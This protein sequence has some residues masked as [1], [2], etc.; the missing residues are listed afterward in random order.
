MIA[1]RLRAPLALARQRLRGLLVPEVVQTSAMDCGPAALKCL[2]E[3][4]GVPVSYGR[5]REACQTSVDG[6]SI[7]A[8]EAVAQQLGL[9]AEQV[10]VP[11][12]FICL[13]DARSFP[14]LVVVRHAEHFTHFVVVWARHGEWL[15]IMDPAV[16][17]RWIARRR[18]EAEI[19]A[20]QQ[21]VDAR[22]WR[23][24]C[25]SEDFRQP[26]LRRMADFGVAAAAAE[27]L[28]ARAAREDGWFGFGALDAAVRLVAALVAARGL[29]RGEEAGRTLAALFVDTVASGGDIF[30]VIPPGYW[31]AIPDIANTDPGREMLRISGGVMLRTQAG[32]A[33]ALPD[34]RTLPVEL[35]A[36][37]AGDSEG[38]LRRCW[39]ILR[40][41]R[42]LRPRLVGG[43]VALQ[44]LALLVQALLM[45]ALIELAQLL[46][47]PC[48]RLA[49]L[50]A[51]VLLVV[52]GGALDLALARHAI[53]LGRRLEVRL[54]QALLAKLPRLDERYFQSR[55]IT[56]MADR[57]HLIH[58]VRALPPLAV[59]AL[60]ALTALA[61]TVLAVIV[62]A[63]DCAVPALLAVA[64]A[65]GLPLLAQPLLAERD[66]RVRNHGGALHGFYL[67][68]LLGLAPIR[69][70]RAQAAI[71]RQH[72]G[73]LVEWA[74][75]A[76][77]FARWALAAQGLQAL[78][79]LGL[80]G[81]MLVRHFGMSGRVTGTDLLLVFWALQLPA[82]ADA[83]SA[84][85]RRYPPIRNALLRQF[86]P[87][88]APE[89]AGGRVAL[90]VRGPVPRRAGPVGIAI[91][92]GDVV[93]GGHTIL[94]EIELSIAPGEHVAIV[95]PSGAGKSSL[96]GLLLGWHR[97]ERGRL[98]IDGAALTPRAL[99]ALRRDVAWVDPQVQL[100]NRS[101][102]DN[103][104]YAADDGAVARAGEAIAA[105]DLGGV[106]ARL[107]D[108]LQ[109]PLGEGG[110]LLSGGE[111]QRVRLARALLPDST[112]LA[113][114]DEPFR[115]L[116]REQRAELLQRARAL[117][118][119]ATL[120]CVTHDIAETQAFPR[121]LVIEDGR[122]VEDG[123][124]GALAGRPSRYRALIEAEQ[125]LRRTRWG[126]ADWRH[127]RVAGGR[128]E[129]RSRAA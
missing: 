113:L 115:G 21:S 63:P 109:S 108:G 90:G 37:L 40:E 62:I 14:A 60:Q 49:A 20:H 22:D 76:R 91:T 71:A 82:L 110:G 15:Q 31:S 2:L 77:G 30:A 6:T 27:E 26:L 101:L 99:A 93:A 16:G 36:A 121:V 57:G 32:A 23:A 41:D 79:C 18:F 94:R 42:A 61:V 104:A 72:E 96:L 102:L 19:F 64:V 11:R 70:H 39:R 83:A 8:I 124:P 25:E 78:L 116:D 52:A 29:R 122:I 69:A 75:A 74:G 35:A 53:A 85:A 118:A 107:P 88:D 112:G 58:T 34:A 80:T 10:L 100:W 98:D 43:A 103:L 123:V 128:V 1:P 5:L 87:L 125:A 66:S 54:R 7:D 51:L 38:P 97:L 86:E 120:L 48:Q 73:L 89:D 56:D 114:L 119:D 50:A 92:R 55:P 44:A 24:W 84:I 28:V 9:A 45:R 67:D 106:A 126:A 65:V 95:G 3:G 111:G 105:A 17:R 46:T 59:Q 33:P 12:D 68:A 117:W 4:H 81:G 129:E 13:D 47:M 127:W